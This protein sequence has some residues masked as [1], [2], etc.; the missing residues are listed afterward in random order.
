MGSICFIDGRA[1]AVVAKGARKP[2]LPPKE[3]PNPLR[4]RLQ[5]SPRC[6]S[7]LL[8]AADG[9]PHRHGSDTMRTRERR[10]HTAT[11]R[12]SPG[13]NVVL[14]AAAPL[15]GNAEAATITA[16]A[17]GPGEGPALSFGQQSVRVAVLSGRTK[18]MCPSVHRALLLSCLLA[19]SLA[20][21]HECLGSLAVSVSTGQRAPAPASHRAKGGS[22]RKPAPHESTTVAANSS[23]EGAICAI[24]R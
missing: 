14:A 22:G 24:S 2:I 18:H 12:G 19:A 3:I 9:R 23:L 6:S 21:L 15:L 4:S 13:A 7:P 17:G 10:M 16:I 11:R 1:V 5:H 8:T 20:Y